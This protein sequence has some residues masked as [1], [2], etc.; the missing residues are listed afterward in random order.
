ML[1]GAC[2]GQS[3]PPATY[4][5][6]RERCFTGG[7][8]EGGC[9]FGQELR[10]LPSIPW[11][12]GDCARRWPAGAAALMGL[13][14]TSG[15]ILKNEFQLGNA[16]TNWDRESRITTALS[17]EYSR[18]P[19]ATYYMIVA[20]NERVC[21]KRASVCARACVCVCV[22]ARVCVRVCVWGGGVALNGISLLAFVIW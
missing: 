17:R 3:C 15:S 18:S 7:P 10:P 2:H 6:I 4:P 11:R 13:Q 21:R 8:L 16:C 20:E 12:H 19:S 1:K 22:R 5:H 9:V 14:Y